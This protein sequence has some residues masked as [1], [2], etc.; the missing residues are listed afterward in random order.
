MIV[1]WALYKNQ[2]SSLQP[3]VGAVRDTPSAFLL[4]TGLGFGSFGA[5]GSSQNAKPM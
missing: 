5:D 4:V 3:I 2:E 1:K